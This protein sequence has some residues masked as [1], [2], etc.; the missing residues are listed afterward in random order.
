M[1]ILFLGFISATLASSAFAARDSSLDILIGQSYQTTSF[2]GNDSTS[3]KDISL[4][5][6]TDYRLFDNLKLELSLNN[7]QESA[8]SYIDEQL[9]LQ[10][11]RIKTTSV[12]LGFK[13]GVKLVEDWTIYGHLGVSSWEINIKEGVTELPKENNRLRDED[14]YYSI[15]LDYDHNDYDAF[16]LE[17]KVI[18]ID[19]SEDSILISN[20]V[21]TLSVYFKTKF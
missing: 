3:G 11:S 18:D 21:Q 16:G 8:G 14:M 20:K 6:R 15:S 19:Y 5:I 1:K 12:D 13:Y 7:Y 9:V 2:N 10:E 4:G 17:Y